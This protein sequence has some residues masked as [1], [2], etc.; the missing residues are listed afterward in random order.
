MWNIFLTL[1]L[2]G[3]GSTSCGAGTIEV[4]GQCVVDDSNN[5]V[6]NTDTAD[7]GAQVVCN[8]PE[9]MIMEWS[10]GWDA[11]GEASIPVTLDGQ[12]Q[13]S[14]LN[15]HIW[16]EGDAPGFDAETGQWILGE[17][18]TVT[19]YLDGLPASSTAPTEMGQW[20]GLEGIDP[21]DAWT[22]CDEWAC[23][24]SFSEIGAVPY[25]AQWTF[26]LGMGGVVD[27]YLLGIMPNALTP[28]ENYWGGSIG[29]TVFIGPDLST[30]THGYSVTEDGGWSVDESSPL[31]VEEAWPLDGEGGPLATGYYVVMVPW[32]WQ[33]L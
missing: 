20:M 27:D 26:E 29:G 6:P 1:M 13:R 33:L 15:I 32:L 2:T 25:F 30:V 31:T 14:G 22:D 3:C 19:Y 7:T 5:F 28:S 23:S 17:H 21:D 11:A 16:E 12:E 10:F 9:F 18:C 24:G 8:Q 4:D